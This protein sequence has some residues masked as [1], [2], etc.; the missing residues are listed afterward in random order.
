MFAMA[1]KVVEIAKGKSTIEVAAAADS[2]T[3]IGAY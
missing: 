2:D 3:N 1:P